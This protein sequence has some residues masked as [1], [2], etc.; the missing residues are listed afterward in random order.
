MEESG[1]ERTFDTLEELYRSKQSP[2]DLNHDS[3]AFSSDNSVKMQQTLS[4]TKTGLSLDENDIS[5]V[6]THH[7]AYQDPKGE[8]VF[9]DDLLGHE[10]VDLA[11]ARKMHI[12]N[13]VSLRSTENYCVFTY[14][15]KRP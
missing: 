9:S 4:Q 5:Q 15:L 2:H 14:A 11:L 1:L 13:D 8:D 7:T 12:I 10:F 3:T 6:R